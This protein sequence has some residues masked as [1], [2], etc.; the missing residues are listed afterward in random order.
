MCICPKCIFLKRYS[1]KHETQRN[2]NQTFFI[3][4]SALSPCTNEVVPH[5]VSTPIL[6]LDWN[7]SKHVLFS[8]PGGPDPPRNLEVYQYTYTYYI[9]EPPKNIF[10]HFWSFQLTSLK[11]VVKLPTNLIYFKF[12]FSLIQQVFQK[13]L[14]TLLSILTI[15]FKPM[16]F[17]SV[18]I[19]YLTLFFPM[20]EL[21]V[22]V[23][24]LHD[25]SFS[26]M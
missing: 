10:W 6:I 20:Y 5:L 12:D 16:I 9:F 24:T 26:K 1:C 25:Y 7:T 3:S 15:S 22:I 23:K 4:T 17:F 2:S 14:K 18:G 11:S 13:N 21:S 19:E 8:G